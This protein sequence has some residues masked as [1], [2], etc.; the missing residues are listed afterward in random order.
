M[1][2]MSEE[3]FVNK[4]YYHSSP[5]MNSKYDLEQEYSLP[6]EYY[7]SHFIKYPNI[8]VEVKDNSTYYEDNICMLPSKKVFLPRYIGGSTNKTIYKYLKEYCKVTGKM[9][10][11]NEF[12]SSPFVEEEPNV[13]IDISQYISYKPPQEEL[14]PTGTSPEESNQ[15]ES[16][17][18]PAAPAAPAAPMHDESNEK[19]NSYIKNILSFLKNREQ[20]SPQSPDSVLQSTTPEPIIN[21]ESNEKLNSYIKNILSFLKNRE[22]VSPPSPAAKQAE[23]EAEEE[24]VAA[25]AAEGAG[26][27]AAPASPMH[28]ES[29]EKLNS[30]IKNILSFLKNRE[31]VSSI[32]D[33]V[34][35]ST[36]P[37]P[38]TL[39]NDESN[40]KPN[41]Y[42]KN[43]L[44][45]L[46]IENKYHPYKILYHN[47]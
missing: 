43:I 4:S 10:E 21:D 28:D 19:L 25:E 20:V 38:I 3:S 23:E 7:N 16:T 39:I 31:Q 42:I 17:P 45:F 32:P 46:K 2:L 47:Q 14:P 5:F 35:Q 24:A 40:E 34:L 37:E 8:K 22:Q 11:Y 36:T 27:A 6:Q 18:A 13:P 30:Y 41:S 9:D 15:E 1:F 26:P 29:N 44:S 33:S 12:V